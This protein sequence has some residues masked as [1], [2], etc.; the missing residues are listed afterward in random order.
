[1]GIVIDI[2]ILVICGFVIFNAWKN[3]LI[4]SVM[5]LVTGIVS[6]IAAYSFAPVFGDFI[7]EKYALKMISDGIAKT[8]E[9]LSRTAAGT[10]DLSS[11]V[12]EMPDSLVQIINRYAVDSGKL[13]EMCGNITEGTSDTVASVA[14]YISAPIADTL[15]AAVAFIVIFIGVFVVLSLLTFIVDLIFHLPVLNGTNKSLGLVFGVIEA[16]IIAFLISNVAA[17]VITSLGSI[18]SSV[19]GSHVVE[20]SYV[21]RFFSMIDLFGVK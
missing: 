5:G 9:S 7:Y 10:F 12:E 13:S 3:G 8:L 2:I 18:D 17:A 6:F 19:F 15:S 20:G 21:M 4:K 11:M 14:E 16:L 1:M